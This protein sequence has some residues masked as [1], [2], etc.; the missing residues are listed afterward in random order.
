MS[1]KKDMVISL[2]RGVT[3]QDLGA[4][5]MTLGQFLREVVGIAAAED[6]PTGKTATAEVTREEVDKIRVH[7]AGK[8]Q[9]VVRS[10][11]R[12]DIQNYEATRESGFLFATNDDI[13][14]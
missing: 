2:H 12:V 9:I 4:D 6:L 10:K 3:M 14:H 5:N 8:C 11:G 1:E 13:S 7:T